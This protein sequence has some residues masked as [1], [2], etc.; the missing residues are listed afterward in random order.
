MTDPECALITIVRRLFENRMTPEIKAELDN[1]DLHA[2]SLLLSNALHEMARQFTCVTTE[3]VE[4][5][6]SSNNNEALWRCFYEEAR[7]SKGITYADPQE[8]KRH[9]M[10]KLV[11]TDVFCSDLP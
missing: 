11:I 10:I 3:Q 6:I 7:W 8:Q 1:G 5:A 4:Q 9:E 2:I